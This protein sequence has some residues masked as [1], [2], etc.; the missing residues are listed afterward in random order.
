MNDI[1]HPLYSGIVEYQMEV[2]NRWGEKIFISNDICIG[3]DGYVNGVMALQDVYVWKV[4]V[5]FKN[6][7]PHKQYG[8]V[9]L[10]R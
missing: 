9:T 1:F 3:W 4:S 2:Y 5:I 8:S 6:G 10:L 7:E